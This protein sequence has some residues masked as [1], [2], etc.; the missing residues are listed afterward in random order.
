M[1][2]LTHPIH[3]TDAEFDKTVLNSSLPAV[4]DFWAAWCGPCRMIAP[5]VEDLANDYD[6]KA[7][8]AKLDTDANPQVPM[9][10]GI[11]GIPTLIF[12]KNGAE[13]D[14]IIGIPRQPKEALRAKLDALI[15]PK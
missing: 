5:F 3:V 7:L 8:V 11:M 15:E 2:T 13:V 1:D 10:Y 6:G 14:R 9:K 12:F 4:V